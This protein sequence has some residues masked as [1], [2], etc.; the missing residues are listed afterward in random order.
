MFREAFMMTFSIGR[1][2]AAFG[3]TPLFAVA[4]LFTAVGAAMAQDPFDL[5]NAQQFTILDLNG[6]FSLNGPSSV[7]GD[8]GVVAG[9]Y[10][11]ASPAI[12][13]G[14]LFTSS[15]VTGSNSG[16]PFRTGIVPQSSVVDAL[17]NSASMSAN[18]RSQFYAGLAPTVTGVSGV[19]IS[20]PSGNVTIAGHSGLNVVDLTGITIN[21]GT[22]TLSGPADAKFV[23]NDHGAFRVNGGSSIVAAG[24]VSPSNILF[25]VLGSGGDVAIT[26]S[27]KSQIDGS[28]LAPDRIISAHDKAVNG[29]L[30][31]DSIA[32]TSGVQVNGPP[33]NN[34]V[35]PEA[36]SI[37]LF[38]AGGIPL[39]AIPGAQ[40]R[41]YF[42]RAI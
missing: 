23:L 12:V 15:G 13:T 16:V 38:M 42:K 36:D 11:L 9:K 22:L 30:I 10:N 39:L 20:N 21:N 14:S 18:D 31:G 2:G 34:S 8:V 37:L 32:L 24:G 1:R 3:L 28:I 5:G 35:V 27:T 29:A 33:P 17:L 25:N 7:I 40:L 41:R 26:G 6:Q 19:N 4:M